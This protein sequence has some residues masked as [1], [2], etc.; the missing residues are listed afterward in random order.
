VKPTFVGIRFMPATSSTMEQ[1]IIKKESRIW[2]NPSRPVVSVV[3]Y[4]LHPFIKKFDYATSNPIERI[5]PL[6]SDK[7]QPQPP[8]QQQQQQDN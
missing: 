4:R 8:S 6:T 3:S 2:I 5:A 7:K 1:R